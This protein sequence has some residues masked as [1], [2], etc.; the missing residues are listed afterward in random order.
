VYWNYEG[1]FEGLSTRPQFKIEGTFIKK[2][3]WSLSVGN[4]KQRLMF[5]L[6]DR[7]YLAARLC[8]VL[9]LHYAK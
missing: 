6:L 9:Y 4:V 1:D 3:G 8:L 2:L 7:E 5:V